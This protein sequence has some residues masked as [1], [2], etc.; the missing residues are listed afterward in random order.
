MNLKDS[1]RVV[2]G[3]PKEGIS[4]KDIT[5][6]IG[7]G[8][9]LKCS[10]DKIVEHL[11]DKNVDLIVGPEARG[12]IFGVPVAYALGVGFVPVRKPGKLPCE[13]VSVDYGLEYGN[14]TL[15]IHKDAIKKGQ[16]VAIVDDLLATGG[17]IEAVAKLVETVG[18]EVV[19]LDF[20]IELT[21]LNGRDKLQG[22]DVM[23]LVDY[24]F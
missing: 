13:T 18:A 17:T 21:G 5:T 24:E 22:Y 4:F 20:A 14:D 9:A 2:E 23:S 7:D 15:E 11:K 3:F 19:A 6:L 1:I 8:E 12:F 16:R 10:I